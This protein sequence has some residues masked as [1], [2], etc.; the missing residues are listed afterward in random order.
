[1]EE[2]NIQAHG[3]ELDEKMRI[4]I[5]QRLNNMFGLDKYLVR[6]VT[7]TLF[8]DK[9]LQG[10]EN[11]CCRIRFEVKN[12]PPIITEL[13][14]L[15]MYTAIDLAIERANLKVSHRLNGENATRKRL[16]NKNTSFIC[17]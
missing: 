9:A 16:K 11:K 15:D 6:K 8:C 7:I 1:M 10:D 13:K 12:Q 4:Y 5:N 2:L 17:E 14:S 3:F